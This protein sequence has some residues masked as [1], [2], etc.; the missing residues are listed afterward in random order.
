MTQ[1]RRSL[2]ARVGVATSGAVALAGCSGGSGSGS[3]SATDSTAGTSEEG[4]GDT[5]DDDTSPT[6]TDTPTKETVS[7]DTQVQNELEGAAEVLSHELYTQG[8]TVS[9]Q[10]S[11]KVSDAEAI[12]GYLLL[13]SEVFYSKISA[14]EEI[15]IVREYTNGET[16][17][18]TAQF[19]DVD[20][21]QV[22]EYTVV[23]DALPDKQPKND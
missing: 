7:S 13:R 23:V 12:D 19:T 21:E 11:V 4:S 14:G 6:A 18:L 1:T 15:D 2:L 17:G 20:P 8:G 9:V 22:Q 16:Y 3:S 5:S 10:A